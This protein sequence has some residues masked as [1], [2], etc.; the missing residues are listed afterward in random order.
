MGVNF[1]GGRTFSDPDRSFSNLDAAL[2]ASLVTASADIAVL[3]DAEGLVLDVAMRDEV[4]PGTV[5]RD[6]I[7]RPFVDTV[8]SECRLKAKRL[9]GDTVNQSAARREINHPVPGAAD[10][11]VSYSILPLTQN[12]AKI[13][14]GRDLRAVSDL[15]QKL[16]SAQIAYDYEFERIRDVEAQYRLLFETS[17][18]AHLVIDPANRRIVEANASAKARFGTDRPDE[19]VGRNIE[20]FLAEEALPV[21][22]ALVA[23][24]FSSGRTERG[25][26]LITGER[27]G[28]AMVALRFFRHLGASRLSLQLVSDSGEERSEFRRSEDLLASLGRHSPDAI[29]LL[30]EEMRVVLVNESLLDLIQIADAAQ[31]LGRPFANWIGSRGL[32]L[33]VLKNAVDSQGFLR[34][35]S[36]QLRPVHGPPLPVEVSGTAVERD[37]VRYYGLS[38]RQRKRSQRPRDEEAPQLPDVRPANEMIGLV[39]QMPLRDIVRDTTE[40]IEKLCIEAALELT[41]NNRASASEILGLSRQALYTKLRRYGIGGD[42]LGSQDDSDPTLQ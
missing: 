14:L 21:F 33:T 23:T 16:M 38:I 41:G 2:I 19:V 9:L 12:G 28:N 10:L 7:G 22:D 3:V 34:N 36:T 1:A 18:E 24:A 4:C 13:A 39:G 25:T 29:A 6:W 37:G 31:A 27:R 11:P 40:I 30:D 8:T 17:T 35:L 42:R 15:Q 32:E 5:Y 26:L 20:T